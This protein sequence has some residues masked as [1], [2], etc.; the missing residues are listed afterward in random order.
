MEGELSDSEVVFENPYRNSNNHAT[1]GPSVYDAKVKEDFEED[2]VDKLYGVPSGT[3]HTVKGEP[4]DKLLNESPP[5]SPADPRTTEGALSRTEQDRAIVFLGGRAPTQKHDTRHLEV[6]TQIIEQNSSISQSQKDS[7]SVVLIPSQKRVKAE[8]VI[9]ISSVKREKSNKGLEIRS[10]KRE[11]G[12]GVILNTKNLEVREKLSNKVIQSFTAMA[13]FHI[14]CIMLFAV[15][16][17]LLP[18]YYL[19]DNETGSEIGKITFQ[20]VEIYCGNEECSE[21]VNFHSQSYLEICGI[22]EEDKGSTRG[23]IQDYTTAANLGK[24]ALF[25]SCGNLFL[26]FLILCFLLG[27]RI[28]NS[29]AQALIFLS[30]I[31]SFGELLIGLIIPLFTQLGTWDRDK[32]SEI[33]RL[34]DFECDLTVDTFS[35]YGFL[36]VWIVIAFTIADIAAMQRLFML[37]RVLANV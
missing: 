15:N 31:V 34:P 19:K 13:V 21:S 32:V 11:K 36:V 23:F 26:L 9:E 18:L 25:T 5:L 17:Y 24:I 35:S 4:G 1:S 3:R 22:D 33:F 2:E 27:K 28:T 16:T 14:F 37:V 20:K 10:V 30:G 8:K 29:I 12:S 7:P 6:K